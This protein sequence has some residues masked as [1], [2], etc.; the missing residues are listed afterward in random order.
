M[1]VSRL[2]CLLWVFL[3]APAFGQGFAG[4]GSAASEGFATPQPGTALTFPQDHGAHPDFRIEWWYVTANLRAKDGTDYG[5]QWTLFRSALAPENPDGWGNPHIWMGHA[6][7]TTPTQ[8]FVAERIA[9]GGI[10]QAGAV[11]QPF[12]AWV[13]DWHLKSRAGD[14]NQLSMR[15]VGMD[16]SYDLTLSAKTPLVLHG[17]D[18]Y[19]VKSASGQASYYYAQPG[20]AVTGVLHLPSGPVTVTGNAWLDRE[21]SSQPLDDSQT[22]WDWVSLHLDSGDRLMGFQ[23]RQTGGAAFTSG[24]W[25]GSDGAVEPFSDGML[26]FSPLAHSAV[27]GAEVPTSW[28]LR[29]PE[30]GLD[31]EIAALNPQSWMKTL[32]PYWEGPVTISGSHGGRGYLEMTGYD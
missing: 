17:D 26:Q 15:A 11:A 27:D 1:N 22:G 10:G 25:I 9:R 28:A 16:F 30:K 7:L 6:G 23:L 12:E 13:D 31:I 19:S 20:Y 14:F 4:L 3:A 18:G 24:T 21:W 5:V 29:W 32:F 2:L 8:H